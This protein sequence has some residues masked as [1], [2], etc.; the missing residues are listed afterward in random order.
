MHVKSD[1]YISFILICSVPKFIF[2]SKNIEDPALI[3]EVFIKKTILK[4]ILKF[5]LVK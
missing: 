3:S 2:V 5:M 4:E 1:I